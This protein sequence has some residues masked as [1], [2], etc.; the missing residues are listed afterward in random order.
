MGGLDARLSGVC[1]CAC[2][3]LRDRQWRTFSRRAISGVRGSAYEEDVRDGSFAQLH[4][5]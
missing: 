3:R 4:R 2:C 5:A 1:R